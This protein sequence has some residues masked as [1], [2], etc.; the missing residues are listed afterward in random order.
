MQK[1]IPTI[2]SRKIR[3]E[4]IGTRNIV[5]TINL[6]VPS[7]IELPYGVYAARVILRYPEDTRMSPAALHFGPRPTV[8]D[9]IPSLEVHVLDTRE[10]DEGYNAEEIHVEIVQYIRAIKKFDTFAQLR[11]Q[12]QTDIVQIQEVLAHM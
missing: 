6:E 9:Q 12:I 7:G 8:K 3:G 4:G 2:H 10:L 1:V 5:P 11:G